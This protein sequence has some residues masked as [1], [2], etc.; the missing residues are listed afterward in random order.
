V[1]RLLALLGGMSWVSTVSYYRSINQQVA[2]ARGRQ[3]SADLLIA[4][5]DFQPYVDAQTRGDWDAIGR[6]L[7][8]A[9]QGLARAGATSFLIASNT[10]HKVF[11]QVA[12]AGGLP[13][14]NIFD[15]TAAAIRARGME[16]VGLLGT[17][18]TM[19][20][21]FF[22]G[23]LA[24]RG[25][26]ALCPEG[27]DLKVVNEIIF[28]EL[29][30]ARVTPAAVAAYRRVMARLKERGAEGMILGCTEISLLFP[31]PDADLFDTSALHASMAA[32][33]LLGETGRQPSMT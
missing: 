18:Y 7:G 26:T 6:G 24:K 32:A 19:S 29:I 9:L 3:H 20:D 12:E 4:S 13:G 1:K 22:T 15:A 28:K 27:D 10:M 16:R 25:V 2:A 14:L 8:A 17:R 21:P 30:H 5:T 31:E 23:E 33:Y 11:D